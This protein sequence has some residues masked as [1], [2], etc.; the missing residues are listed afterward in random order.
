MY[1]GEFDKTISEYITIRRP[2][3]SSVPR[4]LASDRT[5]APTIT[6][7]LHANDKAII[8]KAAQLVG[9][10]RS[11]FLTWCATRVAEDILNQK[12]V[13]DRQQLIRS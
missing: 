13:Y 3:P 5:R 7:R 8:D 11:K 6:F 10:T 4:G 1:D 12:E 9:M 2:L